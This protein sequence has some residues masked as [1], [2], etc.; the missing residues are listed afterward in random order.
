MTPAIA[1]ICAFATYFC[2]YRF[3]S[4]FLAQK[5]YELRAHSKTPAFVYQDGVDYV[6]TKVPVLF[7]HHYAS[8]TGLAPML[9]PAGRYLGLG[10]SD[11]LGCIGLHSDRLRS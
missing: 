3:Y 4:K 11:A 7:G 10:A 5:L 8:I 1:C 6:P 2:A 9:G